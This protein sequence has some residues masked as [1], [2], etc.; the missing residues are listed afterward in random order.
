MSSF[1]RNHDLTT[2]KRVSSLV[3]FEWYTRT[4]NILVLSLVSGSVVL[5][6]GLR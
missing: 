3:P 2:E 6:E 1:D 4:D 5:Q